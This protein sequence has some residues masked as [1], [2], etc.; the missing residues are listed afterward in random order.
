MWRELILGASLLVACD[1][2]LQAC[3]E[4]GCPESSSTR[5]Q[6][7][8]DQ[9]RPIGARGEYRLTW[10]SSGDRQAPTP[11]DC[12]A[13]TLRSGDAG[14]STNNCRGTQVELW[15]KLE[16]GVLVEARFDLEQGGQ[17]EW[18]ELGFDYTRQTDPNFNGPGCSCSWYEAE[19][20]PFV[21]PAGAR[22]PIAD[23][24]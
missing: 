12:P 15:G 17:T 7:T 5:I 19:A 22:R 6:L 20:R 14:P 10:S 21:V 8:D 3:G 1:D 23:N 4:V 18:L 2:G 11:F 9:N 16:P 24:D 13:G